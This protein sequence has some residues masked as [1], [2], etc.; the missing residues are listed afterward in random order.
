MLP[1]AQASL[2]SSAP[3]PTFH[4]VSRT[5]APL[6]QEKSKAIPFLK[7]PPALDGSMAGDIGFD[8]LQISDL[9][10]LQW[11]RE[12]ELKHARVCMLAVAGWWAVDWGF[13]VPYA[14]KVLSLYAHDA[15]VERGP[16]LAMLIPIAVIE[17]FAGIPKCFQIM[18]DPDAAPGGDYKFD[19]LGFGGSKDLQEKELANGRLAMMAFSGI[20]TQATLTGGGFPYTYNGVS[21]LVPPLGMASMPGFGS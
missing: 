11:S 18:N 6:M 7:K 3:L 19:P 15:A 4:A 1:V 8:P 10:P 13:T 17:V 5:S 20:V 9:V 21:D 2:S 12:A 14:P 16:M